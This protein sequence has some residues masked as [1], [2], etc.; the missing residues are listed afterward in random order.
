M[1]QS[2]LDWHAIVILQNFLSDTD[3]FKQSKRKSSFFKIV[4][5]FEDK[6][7]VT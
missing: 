2:F 1:L 6:L 7:D 5:R 3:N 4:F